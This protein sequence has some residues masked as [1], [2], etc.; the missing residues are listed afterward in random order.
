MAHPSHSAGMDFAAIE[1]KLKSA[2]SER[3]LHTAIVNSPFDVP[4]QAALLFLG[5]VVLLLVDEQA[6]TV[7]RIALSDTSH[8]HATKAVSA[9]PFEAIRIPLDEPENLIA[10]VVRNQ[11]PAG[12]ADWAKLFTPELTAAQAR[13]NQANGGIG[14]SMV[15]PING[16]TK[17]GALIFSYFDYP[18]N[19]S[20]PQH[21]FMDHYASL[22]SRCVG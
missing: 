11:Q 5:I 14:Y 9:K 3:E 4:Q 16:S 2:T 8:A 17:R 15:Y 22:V 20:T 1:T 7:D 18:E 10:Q 12:T 6:G 19:I 21:E 13:I